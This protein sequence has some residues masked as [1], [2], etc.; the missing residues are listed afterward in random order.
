MPRKPRNNESGSIH[1]VYARGVGGIS[2]FRDE[3]DRRRYLQLL[4]EVTAKHDW[5]CLAYCLMTN[6]VHLLVKTLEPSLGT[7][8][9]DL[10]GRFAQGF[11]LRHERVGHLFQSRY[12]ATR[13]EDDA[14][15]HAA[16]RYIAQNPVEAGLCETPDA[17][18]WSD[19]GGAISALGGSDPGSDPLGWRRVAAY[20]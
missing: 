14:H 5:Q 1:H 11:N 7:G 10:H 15:M 20:G 16:T 18:P 17:W 3:L 13:I 8:M 4:K 2:I 12:G 19:F 9:Q 6:H